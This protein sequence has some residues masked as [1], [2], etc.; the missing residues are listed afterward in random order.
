MLMSNVM[1]TAKPGCYI[2][3][4]RTPLVVEVAAS[5]LQHGL[6]GHALFFLCSDEFPMKLGAL[7]LRSA[8]LLDLVR[9]RV[10]YKYYILKTE[11]N[12]IRWT[13]WLRH[14][15]ALG[16]DECTAASSWTWASRTGPDRPQKARRSTKVCTR[17]RLWPRR[18][19]L[20]REGASQA[21]CASGST[22]STDS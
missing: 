22:I 13:R 3:V 12:P 6:D 5:L 10:R 2:R 14:L 7:S 4:E 17:L 19:R 21:A 11:I 16:A 15:R 20:L 1:Q 18:R 8:C 9:E